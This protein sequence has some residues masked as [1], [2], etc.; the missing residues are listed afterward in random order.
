MYDI[1]ETV[2]S[3]KM[4]IYQQ[5]EIQDSD[6]GAIKKE[7]NYA[8]TVNCHAKAIISNSATSRSGNYQVFKDKYVNEQI[9]IIR[10]TDMISFREK[11]TNIRSVDGKVIWEEIDY[12]SNTPTVFEVIGTTPITDP[13]GGVLAYNTTVK[14]SEN[15]IIGI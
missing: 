1:V 6:T 15:Q 13:Y 10:T 5:S 7:W 14:R 12:P 4:D 2:F 8:R 11:V 3:M 9:V